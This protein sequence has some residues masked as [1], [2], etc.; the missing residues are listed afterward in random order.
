MGHTDDVP[1]KNARYDSN[2][3]L[4]A[5]RGLSVLDFF[6]KDKNLPPSRFTVGGYGPSRPL[7]S[8]N[9]PKNRAINRRVEI[10]FKH[11]GEG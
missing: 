5:A 4:S 7:I 11:I 3:E 8:N 6:I 9:T 2:W 10:I 1:I